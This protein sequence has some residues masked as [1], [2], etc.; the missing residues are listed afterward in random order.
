[1]P[2]L[3]F[4][5][6]CLLLCSNPSHAQPLRLATL[7]YP[8]YSSEHLRNG[9]SIVELTRRAFATQGYAAQ[10]DFLPWARVR[11]ALR[12]G[13]YQGALALWPREV[14]EERLIASRP[15]FYSE[16]GLF[17][18]R[19]HAPN[20]DHLE[21]LRGKTLGIVRGY[22]YPQRILGAGL[23]LEEAVDDLSNLRKLQ[24]G[25]FDQIL[26]ERRVGE[27]LVARDPQLRGQLVWQGTVLERIPL[28][29]GFAPSHPDQPDWIRIFEQGLR[30]L[31]ASGEY[32]HILRRHNN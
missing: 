19:D 14:Q 12:Q 5:A 29:V 17:V 32:R 6:L 31:H 8:P 10:I 23:I 1:M 26:L 25:R 18:R 7:E 28:L 15:L 24:A 11:A 16:L 27:H 2:I 30:E 22:G 13:H 21:Q 4:V 3:L 9:G 20:V